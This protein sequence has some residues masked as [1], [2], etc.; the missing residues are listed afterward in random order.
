MRSTPNNFG[1]WSDRHRYHPQNTSRV[2]NK[3]TNRERIAS[4][5]NWTEAEPAETSY[6]IPFELVSFSTRT[7]Q[8]VCIS[9]LARKRCPLYAKI[10]HP[11][12][13]QHPQ[14]T[15]DLSKRCIKRHPLPPKHRRATYGAQRQINMPARKAGNSSNTTPTS[16]HSPAASHNK[17]PKLYDH[18]HPGSRLPSRAN[19]AARRTRANLEQQRN[20]VR[21]RERAG[22]GNR[23]GRRERPPSGTG[24]RRL[25][26]RTARGTS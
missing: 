15:Q 10:Q 3:W 8:H 4:V 7:G 16:S 17:Q 13:I 24:R 9:A 11:K 5:I 12:I 22:S 19:S 26:R 20:E 21:A 1:T 25:A 23:R 2:P 6:C 14:T 18:E